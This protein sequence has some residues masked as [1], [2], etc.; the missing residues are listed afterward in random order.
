VKKSFAGLGLAAL[1]A[2]CGPRPTPTSTP[3][4]SVTPAATPL[5]T[6]VPPASRTATEAPSP[7]PSPLPD[8]TLTPAPTATFS[9]ETPVNGGHLLPGFSM[10]VYSQLTGA[11]TS[12]AFG[13]DQRL[14]AATD[15]GFIYAIADLDGNHQGDAIQQFAADLTLPLGLAWIGD[16]LYVSEQG[17]V[18]ALDDTDGDGAAD[19]QRVVVS[20]LPSN[21][22]HSND[23]LVL[24]GDGFIYMGQGS[25]LRSLRG[26][27]PALGHHPALPA[28]RFGAVGVCAGPA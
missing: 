17:Q 5:T 10:S 7:S 26:E 12:L 6:A 1:L 16:E 27:R 3:A 9:I 22:S 13:P 15:D 18:L 21:G 25:H 19:S 28:R 2:A 24:G 11:P 4:A 8:A 23:G 14:Y 20:G